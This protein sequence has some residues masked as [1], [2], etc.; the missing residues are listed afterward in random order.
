MHVRSHH[1]AL[2][3]MHARS[4]LYYWSHIIT[5]NLSNTELPVAVMNRG[6]YQDGLVSY[7]FCSVAGCLGQWG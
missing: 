2:V 7:I 3:S 1:E 5:V 4:Q 6:F